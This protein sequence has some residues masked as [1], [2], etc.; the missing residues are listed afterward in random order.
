[1][2]RFTK[3]LFALLLLPQLAFSLS[4]DIKTVFQTGHHSKINKLR[5]HPDNKHLISIADDGEIVVWDINLGLQRMAV[6][7]HVG[8]VFDFDF[9]NDSTIVSIGFDKVLKLWRYPQLKLIDSHQILS[10]QIN[11]LTVIN[12]S[13]I[14]LA[15]RYVYFY[16][17]HKKQLT[18]IDYVSND[19]FSS[20]DYNAKLKELAIAGAK[21]NYTATVNTNQNLTFSAYLIDNTHKVRFENNQFL[22]QANINGTVRYLNYVSGKKRTYTLEDD[23]N[24]VSDMAMSNNKLAFSTAYG[25]VIVVN[26][27]NH[28]TFRKLNVNGFA[29]TSLD[30]S[31]DGQWLAAGNINGDIY[32]Y[33]ANNYRLNQI[34]K[35]TS[36]SILDLKTV[37]DHL[38]VGYS[39]G[40]I[41]KIDLKTNR[42]SSN[43]LRLNAVEER[44]GINYAIVSIDSFAND[45]LCFKALKSNRHHSSLGKLS[46]L[47]LLACEWQLKKNLILIRDKLVNKKVRKYAAEL[48]KKNRIFQLDDFQTGLN[49]VKYK[50]KVF[51]FTKGSKTL[52]MIE[53]DDTVGLESKHEG[54]ISGLVLMSQRNL[55]LSYSKDGSI[56]FWDENGQYLSALY[57]SGQYNFAWFNKHNYYFASK[58]ILNKIGFLNKG[59]LYSYEQFDL[60]FNRP[61]L[62]MKA[63]PF[64]EDHE[65]NILKLAYEKRLEKLKVTQNQLA[66]NDYIPEISITYSGNY[67]TKSDEVNFIIN[68]QDYQY[69]IASISYIL[70]GIEHKYKVKNSPKTIHQNIKVTLSPGINQIE[71]YSRNMMNIKSLIHKEVVTCEKKFDKPDLYFVSI[72]VSDYQ[73]KKYQLNYASKDAKDMADI[74]SKS[75]RYGRIHQQT[76]L[77]SAMKDGRLA[78]IKKFLSN[79]NSNDVVILF[80]AGHGVLNSDLDYFLATYDMD[81]DYPENKGILFDELEE[82]IENLVCRNKVMLIDACHSG[83]IDETAV[84]I[85]TASNEHLDSVEFRSA[86]ISISDGDELS[87]GVLELSKLLF[88]DMRLSQGT[89]IISS[90]SGT[91]FAIEGEAW[92]NGVFTYVLKE[93]LK[94]QTADLNDDKDIRVMEL[95]TYLRTEVSVLSKGKQNPI[96]RK[97]NLK[98]N[99][100]IW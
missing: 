34:L 75:K 92:E 56:R 83:E 53:G 81:F 33:D 12:E 99:F 62:V 30:F 10:E 38:F 47:E 76:Y 73:N 5:F 14:C 29:L 44:D 9:I 74:F 11:C 79:A 70:N 72:G 48:I 66:V 71:F 45:V 1:M 67:S 3:I 43:S 98:N 69:G 59:K 17:I 7:A 35:S 27:K 49:K 42:I 60:F 41:R 16:N 37:N 95:Q 80:Y 88:I 6:Q 90:S 86:G 20:V 85:N 15:S 57:L 32:L 55:L 39:N 18:R 63:L 89:N 91:E 31:N 19:Q 24:Y 46:K 23:M 68:A 61:D 2:L 40:V 36:P 13:L 51:G 22:F 100:V 4:N 58:G 96:S 64:L 65:I 97:E 87:M 21:E 26:P 93:A 94:N 82:M 77:D 8:G 78:D 25:D 84:I 28:S 50:S 54:A 52:F